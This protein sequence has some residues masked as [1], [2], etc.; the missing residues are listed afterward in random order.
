[1]QGTTKVGNLWQDDRLPPCQTSC[2]R[3]VVSSFPS[4]P[5]AGQPERFSHAGQRR[6]VPCLRPPFRTR[7][8]PDLE[9]RKRIGAKR[10]AERDIRG[11]ALPREQHAG[12]YAARCGARHTGPKDRQGLPRTRRRHPSGRRAA[13]CRR[14]PG[15]LC[16]SVPV[17]EAC[18]WCGATRR[19]A[20]RGRRRRWPAGG[21]LHGGVDGRCGARRLLPPFHFGKPR[22]HIGMLRIEFSGLVKSGD[23]FGKLPRHHTRVPVHKGLVR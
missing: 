1:L 19:T 22:G 4:P 21:R 14:R 11:I 10:G 3:R 12:P 15:T 23:R 2:R 7:L 18:R 13:G 6:W 8:C 5:A 9:A 20:S 16:S 17:G